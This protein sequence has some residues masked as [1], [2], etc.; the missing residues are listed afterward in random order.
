[1]ERTAEALAVVMLVA[2]FAS[3][4]ALPSANAASVGP[5]SSTID[6]SSV[7]RGSCVVSAG[8]IY[9]VG[10]YDGS[11]WMDAVY[12][13]QLSSSGVSS[14]TSTTSYPIT[15][16]YESCVVS[17]G[18]IYCV[19]GSDGSVTNAVYNAQLSSSGVSSWTRTTS[20]PTTVAQQSCVVSA[21]YIYCVGGYDGSVT[22]AVYY[23]HTRAAAPPALTFATGQAA[24]FV[25]GQPGF[26]S[27]SPGTSASQL[28][29]PRG[30]A[31][32]SDGNLWVPESDNHRVLE[33]VPPFSTGMSASL[34]LGQPDFTTRTHLYPPDQKSTGAPRSIAFDSSGDLWVASWDGRILEFVPPSAL[35]WMPHL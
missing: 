2:A 28:N 17:A 35:T 7:D 33:F 29:R 10:G 1:V 4:Y 27:D 22:N 14:W 3:F 16:G 26:T 6:Y 12:Y 15:I 8:Y 25:I 23:T 5:W 32:D 19:G 34:V 18:Y 21:G 20:Y 13:A 24:S 11:T 9:C 31:F 30:V